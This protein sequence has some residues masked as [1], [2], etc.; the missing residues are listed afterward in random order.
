[1]FSPNLV[2][3]WFQTNT[4]ESSDL[5]A[6][7]CLWNHP[8][9]WVTGQGRHW[10]AWQQDFA[11]HP[12]FQDKPW[13]W[14]GH[15]ATEAN[16]PATKGIHIPWDSGQPIWLDLEL[17]NAQLHAW[18]KWYVEIGLYT[19]DAETGGWSPY[20]FPPERLEVTY[21]AMKDDGGWREL[22]GDEAS[23]IRTGWGDPGAG[24]DH[25][26]YAEYYFEPQPDMESIAWEFDTLGLTG[27][28]E[29]LFI[30]SVWVGTTCTPEPVTVV[31]LALGLPMG[32]LARRR[33]KED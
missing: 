7:W 5:R 11:M 26:W 18:K 6:A 29:D 17:G 10:D 16:V 8:S 23:V 27:E 33:R 14:R 2:P 13:T 31:L 12:D 25:L 19:R 9:G 24:E 20:A 22:V 28:G 32:L 4:A 3:D 1:M 30:R 15:A 21:Y